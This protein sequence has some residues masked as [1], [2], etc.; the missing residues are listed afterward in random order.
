MNDIEAYKMENEYL[1]NWI[2]VYKDRVETKEYIIN[3]LKS[4]I[5]NA[6]KH[7]ESN[8]LKYQSRLDYK[9]HYQ[10]YLD[11]VHK[12]LDILKGGKE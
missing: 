10:E 11:D 1:N 3:I 12:L 8:Y 9:Q 4:R 5:D 7:I 6:I 2:Q